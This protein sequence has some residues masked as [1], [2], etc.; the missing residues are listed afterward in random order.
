MSLILALSLLLQAP[1][2]ELEKARAAL[3]KAV[4]GLDRA[5]VDRACATLVKL[6]DEKVPDLFIAAFRA[7]LLQL[8]DYEK[9]R[10]RI[11][12]EMEKVEVVRDKDGKITK[13]D[14]N[15]WNLLKY[16]YDIVAGKIDVLN[17]ALPRIASQIG[18]LTTTKSIILA[19]NNTPEW[20]PRACC[21]E[22]LGRID[23]PEALA[24]LIARAGKEI[25]P[26]VRIAIADALAPQT[27]KSEEAKKALL[28]WLEGGIW[29]SK[30][31]AA[32][33]LTR[34]GDK[35]L[36]PVLM[37]VLVG[38]GT[39]MKYEINECLRKLT[40]GVTK[41]GEFS[42]WN[43]WWEKNENDFLAGTY[44]VTLADKSEGPGVTQ[45]YGIP[46]HSAKV[47]FIIDVSLSMKEPSTWKPEIDVGIDKLE[48]ERCIDV[49]RYELRKIVRQV[50]EGANFNIIGM[51]GR[52]ALLNEKW[53]V[54]ARDAREKAV[55]FIQGLEIKTGTDV[56]GAL[57]RALDFSGGNWNTPP[58][59]DSVDSIFILSD[60]VP[61]V[62]MTD[63][64]QMPDRILDAARFKR[65]AIT[66]VAI[67]PPKDGREFLKKISE[68]TGGVYVQR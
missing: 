55:K 13:G 26:G 31:A 58:R 3:N 25:E 50:P 19:L 21:A 61:S 1:P 15:K 34:S 53:V 59:E 12:K 10:L 56:H 57:I 30:L 67:D 44:V 8:A 42:A 5:G 49:A 62:G 24:A 37:K 43:A 65:I 17:G 40:G 23:Q 45:F 48:G 41:H 9:E 38:A 64:N 36:V 29:E 33:A 63:R 22:A 16:D 4:S 47:V 35:K 68:G 11:S 28:P 46:L 7:G 66:A 14:G 18:K 52:L 54:A 51:Y 60:G 2:E 6:N 27:A 32:Q 39:R 20:Y